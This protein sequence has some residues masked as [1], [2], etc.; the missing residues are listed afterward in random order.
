MTKKL[1]TCKVLAN[2]INAAAGILA[3]ADPSVMTNTGMGLLSIAAANFNGIFTKSEKLKTSLAA[4]VLAGNVA[5][6][7]VGAA[8][9]FYDTSAAMGVGQIA[10][11]GASA[12]Q[13]LRTLGLR[14]EKPVTIS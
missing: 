11:A 13:C 4:L 3:V 1:T 12:V 7:G 10:L 9:I 5:I 14:D 6:A 8:S 2:S